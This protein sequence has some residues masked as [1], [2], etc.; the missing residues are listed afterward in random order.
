MAEEPAQPPDRI[1]RP[2]GRL[3]SL[4]GRPAILREHGD[5]SGECAWCADRANRPGR[6]LAE[7]SHAESQYRRKPAVPGGLG[8][9]STDW[10]AESS[11]RVYAGHTGFLAHCVS[12]GRLEVCRLTHLFEC[13]FRGCRS[14]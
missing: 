13:S 2:F 11:R 7:T 1:E 5:V 10:A 6:A 8:E 9:E 14:N 3:P 4:R 12:P